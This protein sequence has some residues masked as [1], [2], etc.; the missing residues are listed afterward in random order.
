MSSPGE[1]ILAQ[2]GAHKTA[3]GRYPILPYPHIA[4]SVQYHSMIKKD[5][6]TDIK[7]DTKTD[8]NIDTKTEIK[9]DTKDTKTDKKTI[10][11]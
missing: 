7:T 3:P 8:T 9:T 4:L 5:T 6:R 1:L 2:S 10:K 11:W